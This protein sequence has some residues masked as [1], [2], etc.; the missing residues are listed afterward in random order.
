MRDGSGLLS[1]MAPHDV[2]VDGIEAL[3]SSSSTSRDEV[4]TV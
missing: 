2:D 1:R 3:M 4:R